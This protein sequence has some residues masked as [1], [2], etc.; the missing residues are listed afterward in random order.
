MASSSAR[1]STSPPQACLLQRLEYATA[2]QDNQAFGFVMLQEEA[3]WVS[4][5]GGKSGA[6]RTLFMTPADLSRRISTWLG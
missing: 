1:I 4:G 5:G 6:S 2:G 3:R